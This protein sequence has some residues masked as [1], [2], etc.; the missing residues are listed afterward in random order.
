MKRIAVLGISAFIVLLLSGLFI[1]HL[2]T[3]RADNSL[4]RNHQ[5]N[6][7][8]WF[9]PDHTE[10]CLHPSEHSGKTLATFELLDNTNKVIAEAKRSAQLSG[11]THIIAELPFSPAKLDDLSRSTFKWNRLRYSLTIDN[12]TRTEIV[13]LADIVPNEFAL[14][15]TA[16]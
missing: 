6:I 1:R 13:Q 7:A 15:V 5:K 2:W 16:P 12:E 3:V 4:H 10:V 8:I 14:R 11:D 9:A